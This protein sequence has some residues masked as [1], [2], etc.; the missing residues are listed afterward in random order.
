MTSARAGLPRRGAVIGVGSIAVGPVALG[1][2]APARER[3]GTAAGQG[4]PSAAGLTAYA[5]VDRATRD[6]ASAYRTRVD[7]AEVTSADA[8]VAS[9][10]GLTL[11]DAR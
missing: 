1:G 5:E 2:C 10:C 11:T 9:A 4:A 7:G 8:A 6:A 3:T